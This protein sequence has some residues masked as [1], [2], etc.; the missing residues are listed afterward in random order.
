MRAPVLPLIVLLTFASAFAQKTAKAP[1]TDDNSITD[2]ALLEYLDANPL[3]HGSFHGYEDG[4]Q[5][6]ETDYHLQRPEPD[7]RK[8]KEYRSATRGYDAIG[9]KEQYRTGYQ[10]AYILGYHD[11]LAG[12][13]FAA[14]DRLEAAATN[15]T[16][17]VATEDSAV[18]D[19]MADGLELATLKQ[20][21]HVPFAAV[22]PKE[23]E[24][25]PPGPSRET[26]LARIMNNLRRTFMPGVVT[27]NAAAAVPAAA[28][29]GQGVG[30]AN[31]Q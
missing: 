11:A 16:V 9:N 25:Q 15:R 10:N 12:K 14:F 20:P 19:E 2:A 22:F 29:T 30:Q 24:V 5:A 6:G 13:P 31:R 28:F 23:I 4:F 21:I 8:V 7:F 27:P 18:S 3:Q 17:E 26:I 1:S